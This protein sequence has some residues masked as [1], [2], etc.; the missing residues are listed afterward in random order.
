MSLEE[1]NEVLNTNLTSAFLLA[2]AI[3]PHLL[4]KKAGKLLFVSSVWGRVG[5]SMEVAYS[6]SKG[7]LDSFV[8]ALARELAPSNIQVNAVAP[9]YVDTPM[10]DHLSDEEKLMIQN[11]IPVGKFATAIDT[12]GFI[13]NVFAMDSYMTGQVLTYD[14]AWT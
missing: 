7:G 12:A 5:A 11:D 3:I 10:N 14:G 9:G 4:V 6:A 1:W 8:R 13:S 2:R